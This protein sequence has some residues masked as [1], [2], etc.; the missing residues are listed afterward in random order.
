[1][2]PRC[3]SKNDKARI[4]KDTVEPRTPC[5]PAG[6]G[7]PFDCVDLLPPHGNGN[8]RANVYQVEASSRA[9]GTSHI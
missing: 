3:Y 7:A 8:G 2:F 4:E 6:N 1:M 9:R 5:F